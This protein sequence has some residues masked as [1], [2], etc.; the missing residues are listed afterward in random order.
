MSAC[1]ISLFR[2]GVGCCCVNGLAGALFLGVVLDFAR[3]VVVLGGAFVVW[4]AAGIATPQTRSTENRITLPGNGESYFR[5]RVPAGK[6]GC[7][8]SVRFLAVRLPAGR[9]TRNATL[10]PGFNVV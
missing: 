6:K 3:A 5:G 8:A 2:S 7:Q 1:W 4:G 9:S 10:A